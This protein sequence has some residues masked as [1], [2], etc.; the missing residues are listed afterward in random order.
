MD[1]DQL[2]NQDD[3]DKL[4]SHKRRVTMEQNGGLGGLKTKYR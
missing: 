1:P 2:M 3:R 4:D